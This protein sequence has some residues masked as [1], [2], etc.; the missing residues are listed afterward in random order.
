MITCN[1]LLIVKRQYIL[2]ILLIKF[3]NPAFSIKR[4]ITNIMLLSILTK[5]PHQIRLGKPVNHVYK[6][7]I[8]ECRQKL[9]L[10]RTQ[11]CLP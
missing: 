7:Y 11:Q 3:I 6:M 4:I 1:F 10:N 9:G 5:N 8:R 2:F